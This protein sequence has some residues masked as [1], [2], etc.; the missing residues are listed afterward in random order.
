MP[1]GQPPKYE[2]LRRYLAALAAATDTVTL[3][4]G[5]IAALIGAP[6]PHKAAT[7]TWW[8]NTRG[9]TQ[10]RAWLRAGWWVTGR[11]F[12][13]AVPTVTF[14]RATGEPTAMFIRD[15]RARCWRRRAAAA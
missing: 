3:T 13:T 2:P 11:E 9:S 7:T 12:R 6:L 15:K 4:I 1:I 10:G 8:S 14:T 5:A